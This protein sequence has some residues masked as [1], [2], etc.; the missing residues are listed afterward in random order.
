MGAA[1][2]D[3]FEQ[4]IGVSDEIPI[5]E[6]HQLDQLIVRGPAVVPPGEPAD[7]AGR[8]DPPDSLEGKN[9]APPFHGFPHISAKSLIGQQVLVVSQ[10]KVTRGRMPRRFRR[11]S[12]HHDKLQIIAFFCKV[13]FTSP[14]GWTKLRRKRASKRSQKPLTPNAE[15]MRK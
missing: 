3:I 6:K 2:A 14:A 12:H 7:A 5:G 13:V 15:H 1:K 4:M 8:L 10:R 11:A 9:H